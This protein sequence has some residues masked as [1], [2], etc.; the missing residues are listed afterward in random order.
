MAA[1]NKVRFQQ[2]LRQARGANVHEIHVNRLVKRNAIVLRYN[3][4]APKKKQRVTG[5]W[6]ITKGERDEAEITADIHAFLAM[7]REHFF[8]HRGEGL[9]DEAFADEAMEAKTT[10]LSKGEVASKES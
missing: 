2:F 4:R 3:G 1:V 9:E 10:Q 7:A 8:V 6:Q 5:E